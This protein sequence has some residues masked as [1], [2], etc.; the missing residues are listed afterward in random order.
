MTQN[1]LFELDADEF[2][3]GKV[4]IKCGVR[5]PEEH[6]HWAHKNVYRR[7]DCKS[8][9]GS[10]D[11]ARYILKAKTPYPPAEYQCPICSRTSTQVQRAVNRKAFVLDHCHKT[12]NFR[13]WLCDY[14]NRGLGDFEDNVERLKKAIDYL[15]QTS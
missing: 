14:C 12:N 8:C 10:L 5:Q 11:A 2:V 15:E 6:F 4:C 13:G 7:T 9:T 1:E 3:E